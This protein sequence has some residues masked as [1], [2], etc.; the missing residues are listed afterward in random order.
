[1]QRAFKLTS[2]D[3]V[4]KDLPERRGC[5]VMSAGRHAIFFRHHFHGM[6][7]LESDKRTQFEGIRS[8]CWLSIIP[9]GG[10]LLAPETSA[11]CSCTHAIQTS[12][13]Y[14]PKS[15]AGGR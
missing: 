3:L 11:G 7:D 4:R 15:L 2:G 9:A 13:G 10:M 12:I 8:G 14:L 1:D 6:W 5:G